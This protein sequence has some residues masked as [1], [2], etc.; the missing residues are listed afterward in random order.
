MNSPLYKGMYISVDG[1]KYIGK[2]D[3]DFDYSNA[4][5]E[6]YNKFLNDFSK[7]HM[8]NQYIDLTSY[9]YTVSDLEN[10]PEVARRILTYDK[11]NRSSISKN[12]QLL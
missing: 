7:D 1:E 12:D 11:Q 6:N 9:G 5:I 2:G 10:Y 8:L 3:I 4:A